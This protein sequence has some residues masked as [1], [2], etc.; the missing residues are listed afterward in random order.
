MDEWLGWGYR[1]ILA[2][3]GW[4]PC[5]E[6]RRKTRWPR[7]RNQ[8]HGPE[9]GTATQCHSKRAALKAHKCERVVVVQFE[10]GESEGEEDPAP[11]GTLRP[12]TG[13]FPEEGVLRNDS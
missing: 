11:R 4:G 12:S 5:T 7:L 2:K 10:K 13:W 6:S 9:V 1:K 8:N 3:H